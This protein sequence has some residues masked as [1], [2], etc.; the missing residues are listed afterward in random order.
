MDN[1]ALKQIK[2]AI[3]KN[4]NIGIAVGNFPSIDDMAAALSLYLSIKAL[5]KN[6]SI[7][8]P[9]EPTVALSNLIGID[10]LKTGFQ[11]KKGD[12]TVAFPYKE[13]EIEKAS[14]TLENGTL[15]IIIKA[16]EQGLSFDEK[17]VKFIRSQG[18]PELVFA[19]GTP[20]LSDLGDIF[21][22]AE[23]KN[24]LVVNIDNKNENQGFGDIVMTSPKFSSVSEIIANLIFELG[25]K[26]DSDISQNLMQGIQNG[27]GNF[28]NQNT[29]PIAFEMAG[30]LMRNGGLRKAY[31][32]SLSSAF[33]RSSF[34]PSV[35]EDV[36]VKEQKQVLE[37]VVKKDQNPPEDWLMPKIYKGSTNF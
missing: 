34:T 36:E 7:V 22:P 14:Y 6:V 31:D 17:D 21:N 10:K 8:C 26:V 3:E 9:A 23:F 27:T 15:N 30:F 20:R 12:L 13:G 16:G 24:T 2:E 11:G 33:G 29:S 1:L 18:V 19:I 35:K 37:E 4:N 5:N 28:Q 32:Q 25:L